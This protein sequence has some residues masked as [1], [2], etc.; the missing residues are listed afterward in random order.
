MVEEVDSPALKACLDAPLMPDRST[1][2]IDQAAH[3]VGPLQVLTHFGGEFERRADG[4]IRGFDIFDGVNR[5][6][7]NQYYRDFVRAMRE[8]GYERLH[9]LRAVPPVARGRWPDGRHRLCRS[10]RPARGRVHA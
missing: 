1:A 7:T 2:A 3:E 6:D 8:I 9:Q 5:G 10:E 4:S